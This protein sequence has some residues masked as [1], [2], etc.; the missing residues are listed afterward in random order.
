MKSINTR[1][2]K[3]CYFKT[4]WT[5]HFAFIV[6]PHVRLKKKVEINVCYMENARKKY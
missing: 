6:V 4:N 2:K 1:S 3:N 5:K